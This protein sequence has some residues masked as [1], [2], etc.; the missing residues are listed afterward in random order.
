MIPI[1]Q[2]TELPRLDWTDQ[3]LFEM[4]QAGVDVIARSQFM[5]QLGNACVAGLIY[6]SYTSPP[7][8]WFALAKGVTIRDLIDFRGASQRIPWGAH[9]A[10]REDYTEGR[11][12]AEFYHFVPTGEGFV[13]NEINYLLYR[14]EG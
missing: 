13:S 12:F 6:L 2:V 8:F 9:T 4:A 1:K 11:R 14:K 5:V 10:V 3:A 7:W